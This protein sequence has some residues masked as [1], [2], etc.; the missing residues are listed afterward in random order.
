MKYRSKSV[1]VDA[2]QWQ[3]E[4]VDGFERINV[5]KDELGSECHNLVIPTFLGPSYA[6]PGDWIIS[7]PDGKNFRVCDPN[8]FPHLYEPAE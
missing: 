2:F 6:V 3:G 4:L 8:A 7:E 1:V 5:G